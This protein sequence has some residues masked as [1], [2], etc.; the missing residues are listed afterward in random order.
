MW[1][2]V[3]IGL[4]SDLPTF[5]F[6]IALVVETVYPTLGDDDCIVIADDGPVQAMHPGD[7]GVEL[8]DA[9][10]QMPPD[11]LCL[12]HC[13]AAAANYASYMALA[14]PDRAT[15]AEELRRKTI[16]ALEEHGM[17]KHK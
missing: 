16:A 4:L 9:P 6:C 7:A 1:I 11:G 3:L 8:L 15:L 14:V 2:V 13:I 12:Y 17:S 5:I 10:A